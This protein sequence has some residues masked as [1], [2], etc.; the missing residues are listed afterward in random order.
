MEGAC[1][2]AG[3]H[4]TKPDRLPLLGD[5]TVTYG[6]PAGMRGSPTGRTG[7]AEPCHIVLILSS[8]RSLELLDCRLSDRGV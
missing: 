6:G 3:Q 8:T 4:C 2:K 1:E 7:A 5:V